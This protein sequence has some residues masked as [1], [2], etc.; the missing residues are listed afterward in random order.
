MYG[1]TG[2]GVLYVS[3][4]VVENNEIEP[5]VSGGGAVKQVRMIG[6]ELRVERPRPPWS[7]EPGTP[8]IAGAI[9]LMEAVKYL[10]KV[11]PRGIMD[12]E[13]R[14]TKYFFEKRGRMI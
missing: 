10:E 11:G 6:G 13:R 7:L 12:H 4:D 2:I 5:V 14:L 9:G 3:E 1:P 8:N